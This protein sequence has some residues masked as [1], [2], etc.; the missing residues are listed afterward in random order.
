MSGRISCAAALAV[1]LLL[2]ASPAQAQEWDLGGYLKSF[3][4]AG[5]TLFEETYYLLTHR[6]RLNAVVYPVPELELRAIIDNTA[7]WGSYLDTEQYALGRP[8]EDAS[9][10]DMTIDPYESDNL[11]WRAG[12]H[13]LYFRYTNPKADVTVG[14]QRIAWGSGRI[15]NPTD[16]FNPTSPLTLEPAEKNG[17]DALYIALRP[18]SNL[19]LEAAWAIG[20]DSDDVRWALRGRSSLG[21]YEI[22]LMGGRFRDSEVVGFDFSG[23]IGDGGFRGEFTH[24]WEEDR[25]FTRGVLS[26]EYTLR[27]GLDILVEYLYNGGNIGE[28][29]L[30][31]IEGLA[32]YDSIVTLNRHFL[33]VSLAKQLHMLASGQILAIA[34]LEDGGVFLFPFISYSWAQ[35]IDVTVGAQLFFGDAGDF[36]LYSH[37]AVAAV[38]W[39]F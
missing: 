33:A 4:T 23:Y 38:D 16:L 3:V 15:W 39:Y 18:A 24:S 30:D 8:Y 32:T 9:Y 37:T 11:R 26:Y 27:N 7:L 14:R 22:S 36:S 5:K 34:D 19:Q 1:L 21:S 31:D 17:A 2:P 35:N 29:N 6:F 10:V 12:V 25:D 20:R 13:R 28:F